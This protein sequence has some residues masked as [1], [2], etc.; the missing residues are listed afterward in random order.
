MGFFANAKAQARAAYLGTAWL[1]IAKPLRATIRRRGVEEEYRNSVEA[2]FDD[3][4][5]A[6]KFN[7][8]KGQIKGAKKSII[9]AYSTKDSNI[10]DSCAL[11]TVA[12]FVE[13]YCR[14]R[15]DRDQFHTFY[16]LLDQLEENVAL[17]GAI[18]KAQVLKS[19]VGPI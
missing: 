17:S 1:D 16:P 14:I 13:V 7:S 12:L 19:M 6:A 15:D 10:I 18:S 4:I 5:N 8:V 3:A 2:Y 9:S 11:Y